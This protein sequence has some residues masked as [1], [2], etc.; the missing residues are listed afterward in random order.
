MLYEL[1]RTRRGPTKPVDE[2]SPYAPSPQRTASLAEA[3][4]EFGRDE[5]DDEQAAPRRD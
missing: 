2:Q 3:Y 1:V 5:D 4:V